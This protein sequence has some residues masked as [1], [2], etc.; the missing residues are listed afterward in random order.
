MRT[1]KEEAGGI[2]CPD[3]RQEKVLLR[4]VVR[5]RA[6][7]MIRKVFCAIYAAAKQVR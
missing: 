6:F 5:G 1:D 4:L 2:G 7:I 3:E